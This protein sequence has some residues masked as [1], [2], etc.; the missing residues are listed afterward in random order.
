MSIP[1]LVQYLSFL[2]VVT[3]LVKPMGL[4]LAA[5]FEGRKTFADPL[6]RPLERSIY[7]VMRVRP[8]D[9]MGWKRYALAFI[10]FS[11]VGTLCVYGILRLQQYL[12]GGPDPSYLT[13]PITPDLAMNTAV[14]F[15][16]TSTWQAY[17]G[18]STMRYWTQ[19][20]AFVGQNF[21][22]GAAGLAIGIAFI[23]GFSRRESESI[24]NFWVDLVRA[25]LWVL[26]PISIVGGPV[27]RLA[28]RA[29]ELSPLRA[30][31]NRRRG[32]ADHR[33]GTGGSALE[34][35]EQLGTNGGGFFNANGAHPFE[36]PTGLTNFIEMLAIA[37]LPASL[38]YT[39]GRMTGRQN[40]G[41]TL[42]GVMVFLFAAWAF[43]LRLRRTTRAAAPGR[44]ASCRR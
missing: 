23:R 10:S 36:N 2:L 25:C 17:A 18:E 8:D 1:N 19:M 30:I 39:F 32:R 14:S 40:A 29:D 34:F 6:L 22:A 4:Y 3:A 11:L 24:G 41:W 37:V 28:G 5:V 21:M 35:I 33:P 12:P 13:T 42:F 15:V 16:T 7:W 31:E 20:L 27:A 9:E 44:T 26:L 38:T 43:H